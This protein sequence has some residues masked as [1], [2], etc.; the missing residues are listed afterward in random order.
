MV[1]RLRRAE[2]GEKNFSF[3]NESPRR[4]LSRRAPRWNRGAW[5]IAV[6][7]ANDTGQK[8][9]IEFA[10]RDLRARQPFDFVDQR[11]ELLPRL[12]DEF[13]IE[14]RGGGTHQDSEIEGLKSERSRALRSSLAV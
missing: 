13:G 12:V 9:L 2:A 3:V 11:T 14:R 8:T 5:R 6:V 4:L 10:G 7:C 1:A